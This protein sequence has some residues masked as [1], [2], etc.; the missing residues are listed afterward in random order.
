MS[1]TSKDNMSYRVDDHAQIWLYRMRSQMEA[2]RNSEINC[3]LLSVQCL[4]V[5]SVTRGI[6]SESCGGVAPLILSKSEKSL[7]KFQN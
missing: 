1:V 5:F 4:Q 6:A 2:G 7:A 3:N